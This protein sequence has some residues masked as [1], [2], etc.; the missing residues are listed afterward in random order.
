MSESS[1]FEQLGTECHVFTRYLIDAAPAS[2]V[3]AA[4]RRAHEV[5]SVAPRGSLR[6]LD[7][8]LL[9]VA[10]MGPRCARAADGYAAAF[11]KGSVLR[12][13]LVLLVAILESRQHSAVLLDTAEPGSRAAWV[14]TVGL[15]M[16]G[17]VVAV[18]F[19]ALV[20]V[21][22]YSWYS[23]RAPQAPDEPGVSPRTTP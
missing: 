2:E 17:C 14:F 13:K 4:Y 11:A 5:S 3:V 12:R 9:R 6:P 1:H 19:A 22:L 7:R 8:A 18:C 21:P 20:V 15:R 23:V 10:R 16:A